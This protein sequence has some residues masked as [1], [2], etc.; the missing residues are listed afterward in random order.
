VIGTLPKGSAADG[1]ANPCRIGCSSA[2]GGGYCG[3][4]LEDRS[5]PPA[6]A[7]LL[8]LPG[9]P[10]LVALPAPKEAGGLLVWVRARAVLSSV[11]IFPLS[12]NPVVG[13]RTAGAFC[14]SPDLGATVPFG[15]PADW[16]I[17]W[18]VATAHKATQT[19]MGTVAGRNG[20]FMLP[21]LDR[22]RPSD[23]GNSGLCASARSRCVRCSAS[24][25]P[26]TPQVCPPCPAALR[27]WREEP[28]LCP[29]PYIAPRTLPPGAPRRGELA[30][31]T[32]GYEPCY[33][34]LFRPRTLSAARQ[35]C[36][37][38]SA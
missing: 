2:V 9:S 10:S 1:R 14:A 18:L 38:M 27:T 19:S 12:P 8:G 5:A 31:H 13:G 6:G 22:K 15:F 28:R 33:L 30:R 37:A 24:A 4:G 36:S 16:A 7:P 34:V 21:L 26:P 23:V 20:C 17:A 32:P 11:M 3:A 35:I 25:L 29:E